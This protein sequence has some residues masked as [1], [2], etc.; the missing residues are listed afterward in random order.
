MCMLWCIIITCYTVWG[1]NSDFILYAVLCYACI[2]LPRNCVFWHLIRLVQNGKGELLCTSM[3]E[4]NINFLVMYLKLVVSPPLSQVGDAKDAVRK[5][6]RFLFRELCSFYPPA[7]L[8]GFVLDGLKSKNARQRTG[9]WSTVCYS[10][11]PRPHPLTR[12]RI[13]VVSWLCQVRVLILNKPWL[14]ACMM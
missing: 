8:F 11:L 1:L 6:V 3:K 2:D 7:K 5:G 10:L 12:K 13:W 4:Y 14:H 9:E